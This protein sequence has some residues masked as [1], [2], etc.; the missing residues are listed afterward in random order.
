MKKII[1]FAG[2]LLAG[3]TQAQIVTV[4]GDGQTITEGQTITVTGVSEQEADLKL[5]VTNL[6]NET[7]NVKLRMNTITNNSNGDQVQFCF[8]G[9]CFF[10]VTQGSSVPPAVSGWPI[11]AGGNNGNGDHFWNF[12]PSDVAGSPITYNM[13]F[14]RVAEDGT[15]LDTLLTFNYVYQPAMA[16][17][18]FA[19]LKSLGI[20]LNNTIVANNLDLT[21]SQPATLNLHSVTGQHIKTVAIAEGTQSVDVS[22]LSAAIYIATFTNSDNQSSSIRIVKN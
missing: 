5:V 19:S 18:D 9:L 12:G 17:T 16:T 8:G 14:I 6:T 11:A 20:V 3:I 21:A 15:V 2:L 13:S 1:L 7:I 10:N 4:T 22:G